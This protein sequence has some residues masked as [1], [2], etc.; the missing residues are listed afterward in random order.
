[1]H[2]LDIVE[3]KRLAHLASPGNWK[4]IEC[5]SENCWCRVIVTDV[6]IE[7]GSV[8]SSG[9]ICKNDANYIAAA[10]PNV[11][12]SLIADI[13][14]LESVNADYVH[15]LSVQKTLI[16]AKD[17]KI[18]DL[19]AV[20]TINTRTAAEIVESCAQACRDERLHD[21]TSTEGDIAYGVA[22]DH[23]V[24]AILKLSPI[25]KEAK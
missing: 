4:A 13:A 14:K 22:I 5:G 3:M 20:N 25:A 17:R 12:L 9:S 15:L 24:A 21:A 16:E 23:C 1:M 6:E 18:A 19:E 2:N 11:I 7:Q 8:A 10:N